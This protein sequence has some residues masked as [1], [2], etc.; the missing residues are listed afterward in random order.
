MVV[1][2]RDS[3]TL[4]HLATTL[5]VIQLRQIHCYHLSPLHPFFLVWSTREE[6]RGRLHRK[7]HR[8]IHFITG[9]H[10]HNTTNQFSLFFVSL[11]LNPLSSE[12]FSRFEYFLSG[13]G[14]DSSSILLTRKS[15]KFCLK[16]SYFKN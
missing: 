10:I 4:A 1:E 6:Q 11:Q 8:H 14:L 7:V 12:D 16:R 15:R 5:T 9:S 3:R 2:V 13:G